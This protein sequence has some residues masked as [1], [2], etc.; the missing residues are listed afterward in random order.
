MIK[1][2]AR[3]TFFV[4]AG[5]LLWAHAVAADDMAKGARGPTNWQLDQRAGALFQQEDDTTIASTTILKYWDGDEWGKWGFMSVPLKHR[6]KAGQ[7]K[8]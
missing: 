3:R 1:R 8:Q 7:E 6:E 4:G 2:L 5:M